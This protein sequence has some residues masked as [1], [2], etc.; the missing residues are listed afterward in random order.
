M[1]SLFICLFWFIE[2]GGRAWCRGWILWRGWGGE[3]WCRG[4]FRLFWCLFG[5]WRF[6][7]CILCFGWG[8]VHLD[9][10]TCASCPKTS[11][12][13]HCA[14]PSTQPGKTHRDATF[15]LS[16]ATQPNPHFS[17]GRWPD[18]C[19][20][21]RFSIVLEPLLNLRDW[22]DVSSFL[23]S[24]KRAWLPGASGGRV[25][26]PGVSAERSKDRSRWVS[27]SVWKWCFVGVVGFLACYMPLQLFAACWA[28]IGW[29][30][31]KPV[32]T[33]QYPS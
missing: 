3:R 18:R 13:N 23:W 27:G 11:S 8:D 31:S 4:W 22:C 33:D 9:S 14:S 7:R 32:W 20:W 21:P 15:H 2:G 26:L 12:V 5:T 1:I 30:T 25:S 17:R 29:T 28:L 19:K 6:C 24:G 16:R 10:Y